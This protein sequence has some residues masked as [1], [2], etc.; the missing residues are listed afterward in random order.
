MSGWFALWILFC[1]L[2]FARSFERLDRF[3]SRRRSVSLFPQVSIHKPLGWCYNELDCLGRSKTVF[4]LFFFNF[5]SS[6]YKF[7]G[8]STLWAPQSGSDGIMTSDCAAN[9]DFCQFNRV[10]LVCFLFSFFCSVL[11]IFVQPYCD[12]NSFSG[13]KK[14]AVPVNGTNIFFRGRMNLDAALRG[15]LPLG[16]D[17][18]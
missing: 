1:S 4:S 13:T 11:K 14:E 3:F 6:K 15:L 9:P 5:N 17:K 16:L 2:D 18:V 12:G 10:I 7:L 8:S